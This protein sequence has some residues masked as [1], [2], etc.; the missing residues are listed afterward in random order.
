LEGGVNYA[1]RHFGKKVEFKRQGKKEKMKKPSPNVPG[2]GIS[3]IFRR[4]STRRRRRLAVAKTSKFDRTLHRAKLLR[5]RE[6]PVV[7]GR[8]KGNWKARSQVQKFP[9]RLQGAGV[10]RTCERGGGVEEVQRKPSTE[11][12]QKMGSHEVHNDLNCIVIQC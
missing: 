2:T 8:G 4:S 3:A 10:V 9:C 6:K 12:A 5:A 7:T 1:G 11:E